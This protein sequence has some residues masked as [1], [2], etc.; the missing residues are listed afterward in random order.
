MFSFTSLPKLQTNVSIF[1]ASFIAVLRWIIMATRR[2]R[3]SIRPNLGARP[4]RS[5]PASAT[6]SPAAKPKPE[7]KSE[8]GSAVVEISKDAGNSDYLSPV[9]SDTT[10]A[11]GVLVKPP[12]DAGLND[13]MDNGK[14]DMSEKTSG[15]TAK[16]VETGK[17]G[18]DGK[19]AM[20]VVQPLE[21]NIL[22]LMFWC[23]NVLGCPASTVM[24]LQWWNSNFCSF[25]QKIVP[26]IQPC[27]I[28]L[29]QKWTMGKHL[30]L[31]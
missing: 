14:G 11:A 7:E 5:N 27:I 6:S 15:T 12:K 20:E 29:K 17:S 4:N 19:K 23:S 13:E 21:V 30:A 28:S 8:A 10:T 2:S 18:D 22:E 31:V 24:S 16:V 9:Q 26:F 3:I 25:A 1:S